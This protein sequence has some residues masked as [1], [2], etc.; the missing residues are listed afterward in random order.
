[1]LQDTFQQARQ[2]DME[3]IKQCDEYWREGDSSE[4]SL[5]KLWSYNYVFGT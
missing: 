3:E 1:M 4:D 5:T 2:F